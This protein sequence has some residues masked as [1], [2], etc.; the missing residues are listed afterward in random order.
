[1]QLLFCTN[2]REEILVLTWRQY[3]GKIFFQSQLYVQLLE[4]TQTTHGTLNSTNQSL[5]LNHKQLGMELMTLMMDE[6]ISVGRLAKQLA[7]E[8]EKIK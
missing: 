4:G 6:I 5:L 1:M 3:H 2:T 8:G 7:R